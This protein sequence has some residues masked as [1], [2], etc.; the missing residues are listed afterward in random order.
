VVAIIPA[1]L[2][3]QATAAVMT[4]LAAAVPVVGTTRLRITQVV[5]AIAPEVVAVAMTTLAAVVMTTGATL[6]RVVAAM[7]TRC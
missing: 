1:A 4:T 6:A 2:A 5:G 3:I 7:M